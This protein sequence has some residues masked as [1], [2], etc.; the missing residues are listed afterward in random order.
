MARISY[1]ASTGRA[2]KRLDRRH[3]NV[4][5]GLYELGLAEQI[6]PP[7]D[8]EVAYYERQT[9]FPKDD[10]FFYHGSRGDWV[11]LPTPIGYGEP[12]TFALL[13]PPTIFV[14][15][16][17][18]VASGYKSHSYH[19]RNSAKRSGRFW[20]G[21]FDE[22]QVNR[23]TDDERFNMD[24]DT[25]F[26]RVHDLHTQA[27][28]P[29]GIIETPS[30]FGIQQMVVFDPSAIRWV[31]QLIGGEYSA[32]TLRRLGDQGAG[33]WEWIQPL[34]AEADEAVARDVERWRRGEMP[35]Y[36]A[37]IDRSLQWSLPHPKEFATP[38]DPLD[39][40]PIPEGMAVRPDIA[41]LQ[42]QVEMLN[43][44]SPVRY[45]AGWGDIYVPQEEQRRLAG[46]DDQALAQALAGPFGPRPEIDL[47]DNE[48]ARLM[49]RA[50]SAR[51]SAFEFGDESDSDRMDRVWDMSDAYR[52]QQMN[53]PESDDVFRWWDYRGKKYRIPHKRV[54]PF[55][56]GSWQRR[57]K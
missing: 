20:V 14:S 21:T 12:S 42:S 6:N 56:K 3:R 9:A 50:E 49:S 39:W 46:L 29:I 32:R 28:E 26:R 57:I 38:P 55:D 44:T 15:P 2:L 1:G 48:L 36:P 43:R 23:L 40:G 45:E 17:P 34:R 33:G 13:L 37:E 16:D 4:R 8:E 52:E 35:Q 41:E 54:K 18:D 53:A 11:G 47:P 5:L 7:T 19:Q 51:S 30:S 24:E 25:G 10:R 27:D 31:D 22:R